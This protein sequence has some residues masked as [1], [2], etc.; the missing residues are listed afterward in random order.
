MKLYGAL[1]SLYV[2]RVVLAAKAK[3]VELAPQM[4]PGGMKSPEHLAMNP[5]GKIPALD[6]D[7]KCIVESEVIVEYLNETLPGRNLLPGDAPARAQ[8]RLLSRLLDLYVTSQTGGLFRN[9]NPATRNQA[10]VDAAK[11]ALKKGL[12]A[13]EHFLSKDGPYAA[14]KDITVADCALFPAFLMLDMILPPFGYASSTDGFP[15]LTAWK[16][17]LEADPLTGPFGKAYREA[18][19]AFVASRR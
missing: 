9:M 1:A 19:Q 6:D 15:K 12:G 7:G 4:P 18:F 13:I 8:A 5:L 2:A 17:H 16:A 10:E 14:G 3:G 11:E